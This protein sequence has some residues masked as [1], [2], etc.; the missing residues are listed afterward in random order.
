VTTNSSG[1]V[2][3]RFDGALFTARLGTNAIR[4][5]SQLGFAA[6]DG[7][8]SPTVLFTL[9][10]PATGPVVYATGVTGRTPFAT[11]TIATAS[12]SERWISTFAQGRGS[13]SLNLLTVEDAEG[14]FWFE[15]VPDSATAAAGVT[16]TRALSDGSFEVKVTAR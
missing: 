6:F 9:S 12:G 1:S 13:V 3:A 8:G 15:L 10:I 7:N 2:T 14:G 5:N 16:G 4:S 11:V